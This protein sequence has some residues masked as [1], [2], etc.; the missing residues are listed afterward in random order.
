M[1]LAKATKPRSSSTLS[2]RAHGDAM[3]LFNA[4]EEIVARERLLAG[5]KCRHHCAVYTRLSTVAAN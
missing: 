1:G 4:L 2:T 3:P 5:M